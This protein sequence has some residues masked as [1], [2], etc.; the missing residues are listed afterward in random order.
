[1][2]CTVCVCVDDACYIFCLRRSS[3]CLLVLNTTL[4][5]V[6]LCYTPLFSLPVCL[7]HHS[8][9]P[10]SVLHTTFLSLS[11]CYTPLFS[12]SV[13]VTHRSSH[14]Q[15]V[16]QTAFLTLSLCYTQFLSLSICVTHCS[17]HSLCVDLLTLSLCLTLSLLTFSLPVCPCYTPLFSLSVCVTHHFSLSQSVLHIVLVTHYLCY[18]PLFLLSVCRSSH[19]QSVSHHQSVDLLL[20]V[21]PC[22]TPLFLLPA[23]TYIPSF[24][25]THTDE[26]WGAFC[27]T[28][29]YHAQWKAF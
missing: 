1:M 28:Q 4:L 29:L 23:D 2:L 5:T 21:Y 27:S 13:C 9:R 14:P 26:G 18:T 12:L 19:S 24:C 10:Q 16:L 20:P 22:Y 17:F 25:L 3:D 15:S 8:S 6:S 7:T 11:L